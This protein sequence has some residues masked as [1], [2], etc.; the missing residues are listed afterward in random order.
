MTAKILVAED[1][2]SLTSFLRPMLKRAGFQVVIARDGEETLALAAA[3][4]PDLVVLNPP[5]A[6]VARTVTRWLESWA[7]RHPSPRA[8]YVSCDPATLAR[9]LS[10][11]PG[12]GIGLNY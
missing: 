6:G 8:I 12:L 10:R 11:I 5:R 9:D 7:A 4:E 1:D 3:E 2:E